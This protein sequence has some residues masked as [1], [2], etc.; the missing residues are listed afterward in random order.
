MLFRLVFILCLSL[1][2]SS[3]AIQIAIIAN[4]NLPI[5]KLNENEV[6]KIFLKKKMFIKGK[7]IVPVNLD[8]DSK[9]RQLFQKYILKMDNEDYSLYWNKKYF[10]GIKPPIVLS[11]QE[12]VIK[13]IKKVNNSI[14]YVEL[15][16]VKGEKNIKILKIF[17]LGE[18]N[19]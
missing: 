7:K 10:N 14:G 1:F 18:N 13:F 4:K 6:R 11:S 12:A 9:V 17:D 16:K 5:S 8:A 19:E 3:Y 2:I 15:E